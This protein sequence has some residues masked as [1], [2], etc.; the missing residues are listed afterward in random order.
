MGGL[1]EI[2]IDSSSQFVLAISHGGRGLLRLVDGERVAR[3]YSETSGPWYRPDQCEA[4]GIGPC[5]EEVFSIC[6]L[7]HEP[8]E[9]VLDMLRKLG[10]EYFP[11][12][13]RGVAVSPDERWVALGYTDDLQIYEIGAN[14]QVDR[15]PLPDGPPRS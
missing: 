6:G 15:N 13:Q 9:S 8:E 5:S 14:K 1:T 4:D 12:E 3:D 10:I 7:H 11:E 2:G